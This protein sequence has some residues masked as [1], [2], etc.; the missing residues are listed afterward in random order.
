MQYSAISYTG[1]GHK[2]QG[3]RPY[4][5]IYIYIYSLLYIYIYIYIHTH[6]YM[7]IY[8]YIY[9]ICIYIY[10]YI[11]VYIYIYMYMYIYLSVVE[12]ENISPILLAQTEMTWICTLLQQNAAYESKT[13]RR[14]S[15]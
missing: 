7:Y 11:H 1:K 6:I 4:V 15:N 14:H 8:I 10:I 12:S 2:R 3:S 9:I 5:H 13:S